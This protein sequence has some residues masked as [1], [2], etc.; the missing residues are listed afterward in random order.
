MRNDV[1]IRLIIILF[2][3]EQSKFKF[4]GN[5]ICCLCNG[6]WLVYYGVWVCRVCARLSVS[7]Y[8]II[9][10]IVQWGDLWVSINIHTNV[11]SLPLSSAFLPPTP[12][13]HLISLFRFLSPF[14]HSFSSL[15]LIYTHTGTHT[16]LYISIFFQRFWKLIL[17]T[18]PS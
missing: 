5:N 10:G 1:F 18:S 16:P 3:M 17:H 14:F 11:H 2:S 9:L 4:C 6:D 7:V 13:S 12:K 8:I 15:S